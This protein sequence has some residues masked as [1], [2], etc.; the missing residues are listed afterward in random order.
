MLGSGLSFSP[1]PL[2]DATIIP[3]TDKEL[4]SSNSL[5]TS[6]PGP[7]LSLSRALHVAGSPTPQHQPRPFMIR[8]Q[9]SPQGQGGPEGPNPAHL[10]LCPSTDS[11][12]KHCRQRQAGFLRE[13]LL[14]T[15]CPTLCN[16]SSQLFLDR[17]Y[18]GCPSS[19]CGSDSRSQNA[20]LPTLLGLSLLT[21]SRARAPGGRQDLSAV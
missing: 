8:P 20:I 1:K 6:R 2:A 5:A 21:S 10:A 16:C 17:V 12:T 14:Q 3:T 11:D 18:Q 9:P 13:T 19:M 4:R 7:A 15:T